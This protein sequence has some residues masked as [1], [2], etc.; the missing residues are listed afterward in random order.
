MLWAVGRDPEKDFTPSTGKIDE[1]IKALIAAPVQKNATNHLLPQN[2]C[3]G[4]NLAY[5]KLVT[6]KSEQSGNFRKHLTDGLLNT[7]YCPSG[8]QVDEWVTVDLAALQHVRAIRPH[9]EKPKDIVYKYIV[10]SSADN[11]NWTRIVDDSNNEEPGAIRAHKVDAP[12]TR[13]LRTTFLGASN[14]VSC[15]R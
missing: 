13:Y 9:W 8:S 3:G 10:E 12:D 1:E 6:S 7:Q 2:C 11:E 5:G 4:G 14:G 15:G